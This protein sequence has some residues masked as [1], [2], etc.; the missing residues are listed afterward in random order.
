MNAFARANRL[1]W[2]LGLFL[3]A[4]PLA[5]AQGTS[6]ATL[7]PLG[8]GWAGNS[9]NAVAFRKNSLTTWGDTQFV[10]YYD[11]AGSVVLGKRQ[12]TSTDW[13]LRTTHLKGNVKDAHNSIS[14]MVDGRGFVHLAWG[15]HNTPLKYARSAAPAS[16]EVVEIPAMTGLNESRVTYP[17]FHQTPSG[18][19]LFLYRDGESGRGNLVLK[20]YDA[21]GQR[22]QNLHAILIDGEGKRNAYWQ[23]FI[24]K[25]GTVHL[26]WVWRETADVA[27]N[28]DLC[29]ARSKDGGVTW[30]KSSGEKYA[31]PI[32]ENAAEY[33]LR[34][35]QN[36]ELIN[37]TSMAADDEGNP[38]IASYWRTPGSSV[39]QYHLVYLHGSQWQ[40]VSLDFR[41]TAFSLSG[42]GTR[43]IPLA[44]PQLMVKGKGASAAAVMVFRDA[45]RGAKASAVRIE[46]IVEKRWSV[47]D[48]LPDSWGAW[49]PTYDTELWKSK[50]ILHL[51]VQR[52]AQADAEGLTTLAPQQAYVLQWKPF[53]D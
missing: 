7:I 34:I 47:I 5:I 50:G 44:R 21:A 13:T 8:K 2:F 14:L 38:Y 42:L 35:P 18:D 1:C 30:E 45:E 17:E 9:V 28:H 22:W 31:I 25:A 26:S 46:S 52:V 41:S 10:A 12:L 15:H 32:T 48:L 27:S 37:Q 53:T 23:A 24:D 29:Y 39:P 3:L 6:S 20:S 51:F 33:A 43:K 36:H 16:L 40:D 19:L 49:E 4:G 11:S